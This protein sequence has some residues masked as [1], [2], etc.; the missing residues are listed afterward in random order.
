ML[1]DDTSARS[2]RRPSRA[3]R[4]VDDPMREI[5]GFFDEYG[6]YCVLSSSFSLSVEMLLYFL[7]IHALSHEMTCWLD[8]QF[9]VMFVF[10]ITV[11]ICKSISSYVGEMTCR[12]LGL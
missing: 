11:D 6:R 4:S 5:E 7:V 10:L 8:H 9:P 1:D 3:E 12:R 2:F